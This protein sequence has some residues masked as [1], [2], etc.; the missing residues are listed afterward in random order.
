[1]ANIVTVT[2]ESEFYPKIVA[3]RHVVFR[4][5]L[6]RPLATAELENDKRIT[7]FVYLDDDEVLGVVEFENICSETVQLRQM[8]VHNKIQGKG[9]GRKLV[10]A[11]EK[12]VRQLGVKQIELDSRCT[13]RTF[14][15]RVGYEELG[16]V[17]E[18]GGS[19]HIRM[20]KRI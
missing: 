17:F 15:A 19:P 8:A 4:G 1:M 16:T 18:K 12:H 3:L 10:Q 20:K 14:Y 2:Y 11:L 9:I 13:A 6:E 5:S 7:Y